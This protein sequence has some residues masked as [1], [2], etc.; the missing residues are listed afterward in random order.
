MRQSQLTYPRQAPFSFA[1]RASTITS[2]TREYTHTQIA[3]QFLFLNTLLP[4]AGSATTP[5]FAAVMPPVAL[6]PAPFSAPAF[7]AVGPVAFLVVVFTLATAFF[8]ITVVALDVADELEA[9][10]WLLTALTGRSG[11][12]DCCVAVRR[13]GGGILPLPVA[14]AAAAATFSL[15]AVRRRPAAA[16]PAPRLACSTIPCKEAEM[17]LVAALAAVLR[18]EAGLSGDVGRAM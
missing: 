11:C 9:A 12:C 5:F 7:V 14:A 13:G 6:P 17:A 10:E 1:A 18:G 2:F 3:S 15:E 16:L 4:T 8:V